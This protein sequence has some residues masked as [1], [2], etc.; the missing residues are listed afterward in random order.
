MRECKAFLSMK[1]NTVQLT[2]QV[3]FVGSLCAL[4]RHYIL[5]S[6][7]GDTAVS[8][9]SAAAMGSDKNVLLQAKRHRAAAI[10][11]AMLFDSIFSVR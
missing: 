10:V 2:L 6:S 7:E 4:Y 11:R 8:D 1:M 9:A 5:I 3:R